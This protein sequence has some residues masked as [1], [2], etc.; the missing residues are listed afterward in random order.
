M[1]MGFPLDLVTDWQPLTTSGANNSVTRLLRVQKV[2]HYP[3]SI[4]IILKKILGHE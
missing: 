1:H 4:T 2:A 3:I